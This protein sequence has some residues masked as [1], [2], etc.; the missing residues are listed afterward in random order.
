MRGRSQ[1]TKNMGEGLDKHKRCG[2]ERK[3]G[4][5]CAPSGTKSGEEPKHKM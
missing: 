5:F 1:N 4:Q 3:H 2:S